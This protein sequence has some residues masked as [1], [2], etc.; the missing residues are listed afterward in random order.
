MLVCFYFFRKKS[1]DYLRQILNHFLYL[2]SK[3]LLIHPLLLTQTWA[4]KCMHTFSISQTIWHGC[5]ACCYLINM[6]INGPH[7]PGPIRTRLFSSS[8]SPPHA[9]GQLKVNTCWATDWI[10]SPKIDSDN[11]PRDGNTST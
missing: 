4:I 2:H 5:H 7:F 1:L 9:K 8:T 3:F 6:L 11:P 10:A